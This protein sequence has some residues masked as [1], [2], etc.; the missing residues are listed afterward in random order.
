VKK[1]DL[2]NISGIA[3]AMGPL[4]K[5]LTMIIN[6]VGKLMNVLQREK[7]KSTAE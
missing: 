7:K 6:L 4:R 5:P 1:T 2:E 3:N